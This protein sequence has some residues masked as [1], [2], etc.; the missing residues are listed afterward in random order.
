MVQM[1]FSFTFFTSNAIES[2]QLCLDIGQDLSLA[3]ND[4]KQTLNYDCPLR[5]LL[6]ILN[7]KMGHQVANHIFFII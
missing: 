5:W 1:L 2:V 7:Y 6:S 4:I 3:L